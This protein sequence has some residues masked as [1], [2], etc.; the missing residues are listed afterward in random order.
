[1]NLVQATEC[2]LVLALLVASPAFGHGEPHEE[3]CGPDGPWGSPGLAGPPEEI[4]LRLW[5]K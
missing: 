5:G 4:V 2:L 3:W 1:M